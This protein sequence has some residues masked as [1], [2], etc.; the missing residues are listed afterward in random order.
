MH[1][2]KGDNVK[3]I[4]GDS[5]GSTGRVLVVYPEKCRA[6]VEGVN[7]VKKHS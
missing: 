7:K 5:K 1:I 2:K 4:A 3:V 6:I